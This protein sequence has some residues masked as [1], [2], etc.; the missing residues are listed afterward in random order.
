MAEDIDQERIADGTP[1]DRRDFLKAAGFIGAAGAV[2][3]AA[4]GKFA[5]APISAAQAQTP[6]QGG[7]RRAA[8]VAVEMGRRRRGRLLEPHHAR[9][10]ARRGEMDPRRQ[11]LQDRPHL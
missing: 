4:H 5:L 8:M 10:G 2:A 6:P 11:G 1:T 7:S 9:K 3:G